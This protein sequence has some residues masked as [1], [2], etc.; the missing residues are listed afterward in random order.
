MK[1]HNASDTIKKVSLL[2]EKKQQFAF[3]T[4]TRS[5]VFSALGEV[6]GEK[7]PPKQF[8][9]S[10]LQG[11]QT[12]NEFFVRAAQNDLVNLSL[13]KFKDININPNHFY[14]PG[15][16]E[17]YINNNYD[18]FKTFATWYFKNTKAI[19][20]SFQNESYIDKYF[21][22]DSTFIQVPYNDFYSK[23]DSITKEVLSV[24]NGAELIILDCPMLS[25]AIAP[26][27]WSESDMSILDLGRTL[28]AARSLVKKNDS[29]K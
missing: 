22:K 25:S 21:S 9:K 27:I 5:A 1:T 14:D 4:Y 3:V 28:N 12:Y 18:V 6:K 15:F 19:V 8:T 29:K 20:V 13:E 17:Y 2:L 26:K 24:K 16:L 10:I 11:L 7:K 23:L